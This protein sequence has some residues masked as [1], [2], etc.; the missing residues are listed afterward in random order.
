M[1]GYTFD[2]SYWPLL[3][4]TLVGMPTME[5]TEAYI[6]QRTETL[7]REQPHIVLYDT[8]Q[9]RLLAAEQRQR[10][11]DWTRE[12]E[13]LSRQYLRGT[14]II[15]TS[16]FMRLTL[17]LLMGAKR[18]WIPPYCIEATLPPAML[19]SATRLHEAGYEELAERLRQEYMP[20]AR[21]G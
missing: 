10:L 18:M 1:S 5:Q 16:P 8:R 21:S 12:N 3:R 4:V 20:V 11:S 2:T 15:L 17:N 7:R 9:A 6:T 19:W 13:A 14:A